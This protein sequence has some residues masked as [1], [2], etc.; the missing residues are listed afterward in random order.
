MALGFG[1]ALP[2][3]EDGFEAIGLLEGLVS[4]KGAGDEAFGEEVV[5]LLR[6]DAA[7]AI[8]GEVPGDP[9][10]PDAEVADPIEGEAVFK[11]ADEGVL[12]DVSGLGAAAEDGVG[13]AKGEG[14]VGPSEDREI[15]F[16]P[17]GTRDGED[18]AAFLDR[19]HR[20]LW[21]NGHG[22]T[23]LLSGQ[24]GGGWNRSAEFAEGEGGGRNPHGEVG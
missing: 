11:D 3:A 23:Y 14:G 16:R 22:W 12:D 9:N 21:G 13:D 8:E 5:H 10:E 4:G 7:A 18:Q 24:T 15:K 20:R 1:Q 17:G 19:G 6:T 2:L